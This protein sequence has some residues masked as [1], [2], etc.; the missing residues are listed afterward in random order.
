MSDSTLSLENILDRYY[1][2]LSVVYV[3]RFP[4][5]KKCF[6]IC[7]VSTPLMERKPHGKFH[8]CGIVDD[9]LLLNFSFILLISNKNEIESIFVL[10]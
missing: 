1:I 9:N 6:V 8:H 4:P 2:L 3:F 7:D 5:S 10:T